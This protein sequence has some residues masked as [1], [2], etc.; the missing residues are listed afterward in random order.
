MAEGIL[1][2]LI[3]LAGGILVAVLTPLVSSGLERR[4]LRQVKA[5]RDT[6]RAMFD[7]LTKDHQDLLHKDLSATNSRRLISFQLL[8]QLVRYTTVESSSAMF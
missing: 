2:A 6:L 1:V 5:E 3:G 4:E 7:Q 8:A